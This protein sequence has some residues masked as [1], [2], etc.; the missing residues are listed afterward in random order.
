M[1][2][3]NNL[4][5]FISG[6]AWGAVYYIGVYKALKEKIGSALFSETTKFGGY[7]SGS[8]LCLSIILKIDPDL[9][10]TWLEEVNFLSLNKK[11]TT[12]QSFELLLLKVFKFLPEDIS[13]LNNRLHI[14]YTRF[15]RKEIMVC[16]WKTKKHLKKCLYYSSSI[17]LFINHKMI[18]NHI[19]TDGG[20]SLKYYKFSKNTI[21]I[22][23]GFDNTFDIFSEN[24]VNTHFLH[25]L[26]KPFFKDIYIEG[27]ENSLKFL[28]EKKY[29]KNNNEQDIK[30]RSFKRDLSPIQLGLYYILFFSEK[31]LDHKKTAGYIFSI[32]VIQIIFKQ[33]KYSFINYFLRNILQIKRFKYI[34]LKSS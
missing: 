8:L 15:P 23:I 27:Y 7:S 26:K 14:W 32:L 1:S 30:S 9:M 18:K 24:Y 5:L 17:P 29:L 10:I 19:Y 4:S 33:R 16:E 28:E 6:S 25:P 12:A 3:K 34:F 22:G 11:I 20:F 21:T 13:F 31:I 2:N